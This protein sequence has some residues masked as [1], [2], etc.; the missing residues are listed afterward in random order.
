MAN[1]SKQ[2]QRTT[3]AYNPSNPQYGFLHSERSSHYQLATA[4]QTRELFAVE[5][6]DHW[7]STVEE[8]EDK[9]RARVKKFFAKLGKARPKRFAEIYIGSNYFGHVTYVVVRLKPG[10]SEQ[11]ELSLEVYDEDWDLSKLGNTDKE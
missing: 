11:D 8:L 4:A 2:S 7:K 3:T 9:A 6:Y 1:K 5:L 10:D